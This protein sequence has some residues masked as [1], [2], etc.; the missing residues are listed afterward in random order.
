M[1]CNCG[2]NQLAKRKFLPGHDQKLRATLER[3][4]GGLLQLASLVDLNRALLANEVTPWE[5]KLLI[6]KI[7]ESAAP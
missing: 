6:R 3:Q 4:V 5:F 7:F 2:C 1:T